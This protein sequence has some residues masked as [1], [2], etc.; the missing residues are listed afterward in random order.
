MNSRERPKSL[1]FALASSLAD[2][3]TTALY[4]HRHEDAIWSEGNELARKLVT[5]FGIERGLVL[6]YLGFYL[7]SILSAYLLSKFVDKYVSKL[8]GRKSTY[9]ETGVMGF[10]GLSSLLEGAYNWFRSYDLN[11]SDPRFSALFWY[12]T[13]SLPSIPSTLFTNCGGMHEELWT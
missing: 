11:S 9:C 3:S 7:P 4:M 13:S 2:L 1:E 12:P 6:E 5:R 10:I 8:L